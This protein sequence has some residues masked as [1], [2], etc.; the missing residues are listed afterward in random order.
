MRKRMSRL[1]LLSALACFG[2]LLL[3]ACGGTGDSIE[4]RAR[5]AVSVDDNSDT[6]S[7]DTSGDLALANPSSGGGVEGAGQEKPGIDSSDLP[8]LDE[9]DEGVCKCSFSRPVVR[10]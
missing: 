6:E 8:S 7:P 10:V 9:I 1:A 5:Q 3:P 4:E 2:V